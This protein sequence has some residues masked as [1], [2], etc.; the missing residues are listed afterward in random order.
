MMKKILYFQRGAAYV[1]SFLADNLVAMYESDATTVKVVFKS[2]VGAN[3]DGVTG[4]DIVSLTVTSGKGK[5]VM[6]A[7][8]EKINELDGPRTEDFI[9]VADE[10]ASEFLTSDITAVPAFAEGA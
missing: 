8:T 2:R 5:E 10:P 9:V 1:G 7:I 6:K 4:N 3:G